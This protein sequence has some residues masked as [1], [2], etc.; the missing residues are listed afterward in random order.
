VSAFQ[1]EWVVSR[2]VD[3]RADRIGDR[4]AVTAAGGDRTYADL[5]ERAQRVA[6]FLQRLNVS[7][8]DRV[9]TML[10]T[11]LDYVDAWMGIV[12]SGAV[13]VPINTELKG[14][15]LEHVLADAG[16]RVLVVDGR[17]VGRLAG[18]GLPDLEHVIVV[19]QAGDEVPPGVVGHAFADSRADDPA[20]LVPRDP[21]D[22]VY[23]M[24][25][26]GTTGGSKGVMHTNRS[27]LWYVQP[28]RRQLGWRDGDVV[29]CNFPFFHQMGRS[30]MATTA[31]WEGATVALRPHFSASEFWTD[32]RALGATIFGYLGAVLLLL[33]AQDE[34]P[35]DRD[36]PLRV[37][38]G[39]AAPPDLMRRFEERFGVTL[40]ENYGSTECGVPSFAMPGDVRHG[41]MGRPAWYME[42]EIHDDQD[43]P[44]PAGVSGEIVVRPRE[45]ASIFQG[46]WNRPEATLEAFRNLWFHSGDQGHLTEDGY[47]VYT[48]RIKDSIRRRGENISSVEVERAM[49]RHPDVLECA[50][51]AVPSELTEDEVMVAIVLRPA[52]TVTP[53]ELLRFA[54]DTIPRFAVP[55]YLRVVSEL[56]RTASQRV[57]KFV[58]R[59]E[60]V[61]SDTIDREAVGIVLVRD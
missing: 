27:A 58:L 40:L 18:L 31:F 38:F 13:D 21:V 1:G 22:L 17:W 37:G 24:Y 26:S 41:T 3:D 10:D 20:P 7:P 49:Q 35:D 44:V 39:A 14:A 23:V 6:R 15:F 61:T 48:D 60:G 25:T 53:V 45:P 5:R 55:R 29:Y 51:Y 36:N 16:V 32:V 2:L 43:R 4:L 54:A 50:A 30:S 34:R 33:D 11:S 19:G 57:R 28:F 59:D 47:L 12:W 46:Y 56:P 52:A 9:A 8:G 42:V